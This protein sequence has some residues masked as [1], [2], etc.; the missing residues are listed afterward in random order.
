[1]IFGDG[2]A[3]VEHMWIGKERTPE[4]VRAGVNQ[5]TAFK[6]KTNEKDELVGIQ[7]VY[8]ET[9]ESPLFEVA[10]GKRRLTEG[11]GNENEIPLDEAYST[12]VA[13]CL[14]S[15]MAEGR[16]WESITLDCTNS[17]NSLSPVLAEFGDSTNNVTESNGGTSGSEGEFS[18]EDLAP[19]STEPIDDSAVTWALN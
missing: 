7:L 10:G 19:P 14:Q 1:M 16:D 9:G 12:C 2:N 6:V 17:C 4:E 15:K 18:I 13:E 11:T 5:L 8:A 3:Y